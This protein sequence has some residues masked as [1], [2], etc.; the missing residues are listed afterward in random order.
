MTDLPRFFEGEFGKLDFATM[1]EMMKRL[2]LLLPLAQAAASGGG[3]K[4]Q[5]RPLIFPVYAERKGSREEDGSQRY[6]WWE[7]T[8][9][10]DDMA[11]AGQDSYRLT[12]A[13]LNRTP[14][15]SAKASRSRS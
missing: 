2:D 4:P 9:V 7:I 5:E 13:D 10:D 1:N 3:W 15:H 6:D 12:L 8:V 14:G 11:W